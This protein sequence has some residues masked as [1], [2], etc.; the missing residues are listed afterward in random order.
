MVQQ[1]VSLWLELYSFQAFKIMLL[2]LTMDSRR[3]AGYVCI[4]VIISYFSLWDQAICIHIV[5]SYFTLSDQAICIHIVISYFTLSDQAICIHIVIS[6][7][8]LSDQAICIHIVISY[9]TLSDQAICIYVVISYF[10]LSDQAIWIHVV[11]SYFTLSDQAIWIH[12]V[13]SYF[14][15]WDQ[16]PVPWRLMTVKWWQLSQSN[17]HSTIGTRQTEYHGALPSS[18]N[19]EMRCDCTFANGG[20]ASWYLVCRV[21][22]VE[23][24]L[25]CQASS[26]VLHTIHYHVCL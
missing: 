18:A 15:L 20:N 8:T 1:P 25:D 23:W 7:F 14:T 3:P 19:D 12:V 22:I 10:T 11:I 2:T 16:G 21:L 26:G 4:H 5:I 17:C 9:F 6:Y 24:R 13:I